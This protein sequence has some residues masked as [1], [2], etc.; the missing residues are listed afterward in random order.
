MRPARIVET[1]QDLPRQGLMLAVRAYRLLL[2]PWLGNACRFEPTCSAYTLEALQLH[3][4][5]RG[6]AL[7]SWRVMRCHPWCDGGHDAVPAHFAGSY[8]SSIGNH[9][10][11]AVVP[12]SELSEPSDPSPSPRNPS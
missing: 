9:A 6:T 12:A 10:I 11:E 5:W 7:G 8:S 3:G 2:K 4:A 1:L